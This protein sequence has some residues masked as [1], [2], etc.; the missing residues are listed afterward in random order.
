MKEDLAKAMV[1]RYHSRAAAEHEAQEFI[2][3]HR[4][5]EKPKDINEVTINK[6]SIPLIKFTQDVEEAGKALA[7]D[8]PYLLVATGTAATNSEARRLI[9]QGAV[10]VDEE[11]IT[12]IK[13]INF[14]LGISRDLKVGKRQF[15]R[16][17]VVA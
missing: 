14:L 17:K 7:I 12:E 16:V 2:R 4:E 9:T 6:D 11:K 3:V 8:L 1:A 15:K 10:Q 5:K 13:K